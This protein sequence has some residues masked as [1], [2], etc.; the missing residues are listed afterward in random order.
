MKGHLFATW[1]LKQ[2]DKASPCLISAGNACLEWVQ[3]FSALWLLKI[4]G[5]APWVQ[6]WGSQI[7]FSKWANLQIWTPQ[8]IKIN[9]IWVIKMP[10]HTDIIEDISR[11]RIF[12]FCFQ[13]CCL[14]FAIWIYTSV[15][16]LLFL[17]HPFII[18]NYS[19]IFFNKEAIQYILAGQAHGK[20]SAL[21]EFLQTFSLLNQ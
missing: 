10:F 12:A 18:Q 16:S 15:S 11:T 17:L 14:A 7:N 8:I 20:L 4:T 5:K 21:P 2:D 1:E 13:T 6:N 3:C 9:S 19:G